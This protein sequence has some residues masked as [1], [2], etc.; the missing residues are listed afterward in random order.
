VLMAREQR[1]R[2]GERRGGAG[3]QPIVALNPLGGKREGG[4]KGR[5]TAA[6]EA[7]EET[8]EKLSAEAWRGISTGA[9]GVWAG[10]ATRAYVYVY[11]CSPDTRDA[12]LHE[13]WSRVPATPTLLG[14]EWVPIASLLND[15]WCH[16]HCHRFGLELIAAARPLL[17]QAMPGAAG[18]SGSG[19]GSDANGAAAKQEL[20]EL[21]ALHS[22]IVR[23]EGFHSVARGFDARCEAAGGNGVGPDGGV[24]LTDSY[25][26]T[27]GRRY[28]DSYG[29]PRV[30]SEKRWQGA[31]PRTAT[32]QG[33]HSDLRAI[34][35]GGKAHDVDC[36]NGD[37]RV[38]GSL[39]T[40]TGNE[41]LV[42]AVFDYVENRQMYLD[43][44]CE[45]H[46]CSKGVAKR[47]PNVVG[48][49]GTYYTWR[50]NNELH[51][52]SGGL[53]V[54][55]G[56]KCKAFL[57]PKQCRRDE[58]NVTRQLHALRAALFDHPR[59]KATVEAERGRLLREKLKPAWQHDA[60]LWST[61][62]VQ[63]SEDE[64]LGIVERALLAIGWDV[65]A[66]V[67]D[68]L[69]VAPSAA[70]TEPDD[71]TKALEA[72]EAAC[73]ERGWGMIKLIEKPLHGLQHETPKSIA[74]ARAALE[75]W[76]CRQA[77]AADMDWD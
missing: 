64:V 55:D 66:L 53:A 37:Y 49:G 68:G 69:I 7:W 34:C 24:E 15:A 33:G 67:F 18:P 46:G 75:N 35:C 13:L 11:H 40:Q 20:T 9:P 47:L 74:N 61:C 62:V 30:E 77:C 25:R 71:V 73:K 65:W 50:R 19:S 42:P 76:E 22:D 44:I 32:L 5:Q 57:P 56:K 17:Q 6:R 21:D 38:I 36:D 29:L 63:A 59:F 27:V 31:P 70:C 2:F 28:V 54:F 4:E 48:N 14:V 41:H 1:D 60:S 72:A 23:F 8:A 51:A 16:Q 3:R 39:A 12:G 45:L 26:Q 52:P 10:D 43:E 58:P